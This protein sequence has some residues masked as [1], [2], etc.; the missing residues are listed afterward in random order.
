MQVAG[1]VEGLVELPPGP[2]LAAA[3]AGVDLALVP[4]DRILGALRAQYRQ[5]CHEQARMAAVVAEV[6]RCEGA[7]EPGAVVRLGAPERFAPG[8]TRVALR[9]TRIAGAGRG[10]QARGAP[11][12]DR[13][14][15]LRPVP[16]AARRQVP[17]P[18]R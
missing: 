6:G 15:P 14:D 10:G 18:Q 12:L 16:R 7:V 3:L 13:A 17:P 5:L 8:E 9:W 2:G 11:R 1:V 4:N